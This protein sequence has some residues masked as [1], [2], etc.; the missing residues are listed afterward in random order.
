MAA[1]PVIYIAQARANPLTPM[2]PDLK[3]TRDQNQKTFSTKDVN[4]LRRWRKALN[5]RYT[6]TLRHFG[7]Y[8]VIWRDTTFDKKDITLKD[9]RSGVTALPENLAQSFVQIKSNDRDDKL[10]TV[11]I[12]FKKVRR[13]G[14]TCLVQGL[15]CSKWAQ[16]EY[17]QLVAMVESLKLHEQPNEDWVAS[18]FHRPAV[19]Q[20]TCSDQS[21]EATPSPAHQSH[22]TEQ[23]SA[24][25]L[26]SVPNRP[27]CALSKQAGVHD[28]PMTTPRRPVPQRSHDRDSHVTPLPA[29]VSPSSGSKQPFPLHSPTSST[30]LSPN[31]PSSSPLPPFPDDDI[32]PVPAV[33]D[34]S[35]GVGKVAGIPGTPDS[36]VVY[37]QPDVHD[38]TPNSQTSTTSPSTPLPSSAPVGTS[39]PAS[40][41]IPPP[42]SHLAMHS[43]VPS[44]QS[45]ALS[46]LPVAYIL[47]T[48]NS[49]YT[50]VEVLTQ[51]L[52]NTKGELAT[53]QSRVS[54][55]DELI[56]DTA[57]RASNTC[58]V[59]DRE[60][61]GLQDKVNR[62]DVRVSSLSTAK[63]SQDSTLR[64]IKKQMRKMS[65]TNATHPMPADTP[66]HSCG[67][68]D[69]PHNTAVTS[70][71]CIPV[72]VTSDRPASASDGLTRDRTQNRS[73]QLCHGPS[74]DRATRPLS[75]A[76][77][78]RDR[79]KQPDHGASR[80]L[81]TNPMPDAA[82]ARDSSKRP[83]HSPSWTPATHLQSPAQHLAAR[84]VQV[85]SHHL[86]I[87]D[88]VLRY[89]KGRKMGCRRGERV[90]V[91]SVSGMTAED[92]THWLMMQP[93]APHVRM[94]TFHVGVNDCKRREVT[95]CMWDKLISQCHRVF[96]DAH[97]QAS[98]ILPIKRPNCALGQTV[99]W[100]NA[101]L[102]AV[103]KRRGAALI[104]NAEAFAP[105]GR[106]L[107]DLY[108]EHRHD[109]VHPSH[110]G[111]IVLA[112]NI[113]KTSIN[114]AISSPKISETVSD[115][116][117][118][119]VEERLQELRVASSTT[120][121]M[122]TRSGWLY[123]DYRHQ[124]YPSY[125][126]YD[127][128]DG[129]HWYN[130]PYHL[131]PQQPAQHS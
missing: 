89:M 131:M 17:H 119:M 50:R 68:A 34:S 94:V 32:T 9:L 102:A 26:R 59:S 30:L 61:V 41:V 77:A 122:Q 85:S 104:D 65:P 75:D 90:Q 124:M 121:A 93:E 11:T 100:S 67:L 44:L 84:R 46:Q 98:T 40:T 47:N 108:R 63:K 29:T 7:D 130:R 126:A 105:R 10:I 45:L 62:I 38:A 19:I 28:G 43:S 4:V 20:P 73:Q 27:V 91:I 88:S 3:D 66:G 42:Q 52:I 80:D 49:L 74:R 72:I 101:N 83:G 33:P 116:I 129:G 2:S 107:L 96:P 70:G 120:N 21:G 78:A 117:S 1:S 13:Q 8:T 127:S 60:L 69:P 123:E 109:L 48:L 128:A 82:T 86:I 106:P 81:A 5:I 111:L 22:S 58:K 56:R 103:C 57:V 37:V 53:T 51:E 110:S 115:N 31:L 39:T 87:G 24:E 71:Q 95:S 113:R 92:L 64:D 15:K 23:S 99:T 114:S 25:D 16:T 76:L 14:G 36:S 6:Q 55:L 112:R 97:I 54:Q 79:R 12:Y 35:K 118:A 18:Q 125:Q